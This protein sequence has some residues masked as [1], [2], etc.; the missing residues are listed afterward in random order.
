VILHEYR[1]DTCVKMDEIIRQVNAATY[2]KADL[3]ARDRFELN[4]DAR[5]P[6]ILS[7]TTQADVQ[8]LV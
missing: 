6:S 4:N 8:N 2:V 3:S 5:D 7:H 1:F